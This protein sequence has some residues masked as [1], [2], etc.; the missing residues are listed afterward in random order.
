M[1]TEPR[2]FETIPGR[3]EAPLASLPRPCVA[4]CVLVLLPTIASS[5][6]RCLDGGVS[7]VWLDLPNVVLAKL[8]LRVR[9]VDRRWDNNIVSH[10]PVNR[11]CDTLLVAGL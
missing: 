9:S 8:L 4:A 11:S 10:L 3:I 2:M 5:T 1:L 7:E 6:I